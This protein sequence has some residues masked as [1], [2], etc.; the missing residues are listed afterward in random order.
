MINMTTLHNALQLIYLMV[1]DTRVT[2][3]RFRQFRYDSHRTVLNINHLRPS[4]CTHRLSNLLRYIHFCNATYSITPL[5]S[6]REIYR[7]LR[8]FKY[9][10]V[11]SL[12]HLKLSMRS[13]LFA[14]RGKLLIT[15]VMRNCFFFALH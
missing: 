6:Q 9:F 7:P 15:E 8:V 3:K 12:M 11:I 10:H 13:G 2:K 1:I 5:I 4:E 14:F